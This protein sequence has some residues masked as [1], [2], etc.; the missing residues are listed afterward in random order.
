MRLR[1]FTILMGGLLSASS[2]AVTLN[3]AIQSSLLHN[4]DSKSS[5]SSTESDKHTITSARVSLFVPTV[6]LN[7]QHNRQKEVQSGQPTSRSTD[8]NPSVTF[9]WSPVTSYY[10]LQNA[11]QT[12][13]YDQ[14]Q[15]ILNDQST[16]QSTVAAY[17]KLVAAQEKLK[18]RKRHVEDLRS[19]Y[20]GIARPSQGKT[21]RVKADTSFVLTL[22]QE[23]ESKLELA[24]TNVE[25]HANQFENVT[26]VAPT[27]L[28][29]FTT[30]IHIPTDL[31]TI[32][33]SIREHNI[34]ILQ[35]K[36]QVTLNRNQMNQTRSNFAPTP[37]ITLSRDMNRSP[38]NPVGRTTTVS[39][40]LDMYL[41]ASNFPTISANRATLT[42]SQ[43][44][45]QQMERKKLHEA[46]N[47]LSTIN[48]LGPSI[49]H[50]N[51]AVESSKIAFKER[52]A[53]YKEG[54][55]GATELL[56]AREMLSDQLEHVLDLYTSLAISK[57]KI[58]L[59]MDKEVKV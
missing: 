43:F 50:A 47:L 29:G 36:I 23:A 46:S 16:V 8:K 18:H 7:Y 53:E 52:L 57:S 34:N 55:V 44:S 14:Y 26:F 5:V 37:S 31:N 51:K 1:N 9:Q 15:K 21:E 35:Q 33:Q 4:L 20:N 30:G 56:I 48:G 12:L 13:D 6:D 2:Y 11:R 32:N 41:D 54:K 17:N 45:L 40:S 22:L 19:I 3:E 10:S 24:K 38:N 28:Q 59:L 39:F 58:L 27:H 25:T 49:E 42:A